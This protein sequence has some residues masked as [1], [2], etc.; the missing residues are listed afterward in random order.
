MCLSNTD[1]MK[2]KAYDAMKL[3]EASAG[4]APLTYLR[5]WRY[6]ILPLDDAQNTRIFPPG[7]R[8]CLYIQ[9]IFPSIA[10]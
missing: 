1:M 3:C 7:K 5:R 6:H 10:I 9:D 4:M 2:K 8:V